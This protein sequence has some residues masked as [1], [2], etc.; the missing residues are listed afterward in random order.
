MSRAKMTFK[1]YIIKRNIT[2]TLQGD[3]I[4]DVQSD[5]S[6]PDNIETFRQL[7]AYLDKRNADSKVFPAAKKIWQQYLRI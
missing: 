3:F 4:R 6:F 2:D 5:I 7:N 1:N